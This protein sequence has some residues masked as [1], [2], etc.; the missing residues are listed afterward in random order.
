MYQQPGM[1]MQQPMGMM[2]SNN[3]A[4]NNTTIIM[5]QAAPQVDN[6]GYER[7]I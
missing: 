4:V 5:Q 6:S 7:S 1:Q 2:S 3:T